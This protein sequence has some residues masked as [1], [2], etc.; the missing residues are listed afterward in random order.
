MRIE[1]IENKSP[2]SHVV[3]QKEPDPV[4]LA[5]PFMEREST[6]ELIRKIAKLKKRTRRIAHFK[7][8]YDLISKK[9]NSDLGKFIKENYNTLPKDDWGKIV[10]EQLRAA[11]SYKIKLKSL[12]KKFQ[13]EFNKSQE[14]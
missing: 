3:A 1:N 12:T 11:V 8:H 4:D 7:K 9:H 5:K 6:K 14:S 2:V 13:D 10:F